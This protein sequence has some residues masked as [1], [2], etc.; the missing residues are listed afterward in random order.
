MRTWCG[1]GNGCS[2][3]M[4]SPL[5]D[6][7]PRSVAPAAT[8]S[9]HQSA[10][11]GGTWMPTPG[12]SRCASPISRFISSIET[13]VAHSGRSRWD[14]SETPVRQNRSADAVAMSAGSSP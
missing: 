12:S 6:S 7:P 2:G 9:G 13:G 10:R 1:L 8:S 3:E 11:F 4:W 14:A 5:A